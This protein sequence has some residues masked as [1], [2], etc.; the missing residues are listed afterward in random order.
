[1]GAGKQPVD[2]SL[3]CVAVIQ[4]ALLGL[5]ERAGMLVAEAWL[6]Q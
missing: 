2:S 5:C 6:W 1:M 3:F 4:W